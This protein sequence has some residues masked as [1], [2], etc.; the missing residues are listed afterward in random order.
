[1]WPDQAA[2]YSHCRARHACCAL[3]ALGY[4]L[5]FCCS[6]LTFAC[7]YLK[8]VRTG[9]NTLATAYTL[10]AG[11]THTHTHPHPHTD[12]TQT[13]THTHTHLAH[14]AMC[15]CISNAHLRFRHEKL[16]PQDVCFNLLPPVAH[17]WHGADSPCTH[18]QR[19]DHVRMT[20]HQKG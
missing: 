6:A 13:H 16:A 14:C 15:P 7:F 10:Q 19:P 8:C 9:T 5:L 12:T 11:H 20:C 1:M 18:P 17:T 3:C 4:A 2:D